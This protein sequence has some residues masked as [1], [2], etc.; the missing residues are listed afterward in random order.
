[1][2]PSDESGALDRPPS[3][4]AP[5]QRGG[6]HLAGR[7]VLLCRGVHPRRGR[8]RL[9]WAAEGAGLCSLLRRPT[10]TRTEQMGVTWGGD[11]SGKGRCLVQSRWDS[12]KD[13]EALAGGTK[14]VLKTLP[15]PTCLFQ[16]ASLSF[17]S[18]GARPA[19]RVLDGARVPGV[20][21]S[22]WKELTGTG[23]DTAVCGQ[24]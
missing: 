16:R 12:G 20:G 24:C 22:L 14:G 23:R 21:V 17:L 1:M 18:H 7:G 11:E 8:L 19:G 9:D 2:C 15:G 13:K 6:M 5:P 10:P 4:V 3:S